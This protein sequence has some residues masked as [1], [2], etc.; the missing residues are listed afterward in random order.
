MLLFIL[1]RQSL[2]SPYLRYW[3]Q[4]L[5][6]PAG[7]QRAYRAVNNP[8]SNAAQMTPYAVKES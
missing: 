8:A 4:S 7:W 6:P 2:L 3:L 1:S 5:M